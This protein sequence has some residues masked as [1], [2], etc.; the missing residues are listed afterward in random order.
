MA[1]HFTITGNVVA[2]PETRLLNDGKQVTEI[3]V[4]STARKKQGNEWID[5]GTTWVTVTAWDKLSEQVAKN[6]H[7]G[8]QV[9]VQGALRTQEFRT[10]AGENASKLVMNADEI[11]VSLRR[12]DVNYTKAGEGSQGGSA[13]PWGG[14]PAGNPTNEQAPF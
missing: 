9:I 11:G 4:A 14:G 7:K 13:S 5:E 2:E 8:V 1:N 10:K 3:R 12:H 6:L